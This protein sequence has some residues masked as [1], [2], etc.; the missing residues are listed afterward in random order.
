M[1][2]DN[3]DDMAEPFRHVSD[4]QWV[5]SLDSTGIEWDRNEK[6]R[7]YMF[8]I[9][10]IAEHILKRWDLKLEGEVWYQGED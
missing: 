10:W 4:C 3:W 7:D 9:N 5:P 8:W 6:F 2:L 1:E